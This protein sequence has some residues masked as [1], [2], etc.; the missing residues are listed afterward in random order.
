MCLSEVVRP[1][2]TGLLL[3]TV[4]IVASCGV[5]DAQVIDLKHSGGKIDLA[6][7]LRGDWERVCI[8]MPYATSEQAKELLGVSYSPEVHSAIAVKDDRTLLVT[9]KSNEVLGSFEVMR[10]VADFTQIGAGCY[11]RSEAVF[12]YLSK[13]GGWHEVS[14]T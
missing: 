8:L 10:E 4:L 14:D 1:I 13:D 6:A 12:N 5:R 3:A 2:V 11:E 7:Q 9:I